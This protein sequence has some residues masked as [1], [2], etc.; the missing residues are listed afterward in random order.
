MRQNCNQ[1]LAIRPL[2]PTYLPGSR[3]HPTSTIRLCH[4]LAM[5]IGIIAT[6]LMLVIGFSG[7][8]WRGVYLTRSDRESG[9]SELARARLIF[10]SSIIVGGIVG[11]VGGITNVSILSYIGATIFIAGLVSWI[12]FLLIDLLQSRK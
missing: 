1:A 6:V 4:A 12:G 10:Y 7:I 8:I 9:K 3:Y 11:T 2:T 5:V